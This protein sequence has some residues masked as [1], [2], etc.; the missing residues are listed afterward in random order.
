MLTRQIPNLLTLLNLITGCLSILHT[1]NGDLE[2][3]GYY[4]MMGIILDFSDG[5]VARLLKASSA[6]GKQLDSFSDLVTFGIAPSFILFSFIKDQ[7]IF[8]SYAAFIITITAAIRLARFNI[9]EDSRSFR[10]IPTPATAL[11]IV[12]FIFIETD[13]LNQLYIQ[14]ILIGLISISSVV[15]LKM[16]ALKFSHNKWKGNETK[17]LLIITSLLLIFTLKWLAIPIIMIL[18]VLL[19]IIQYTLIERK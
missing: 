6:I 14:I 16:I 17:Y 19:S 10:G 8:V 9:Q 5:F 3:G 13:F 12:S 18:Y 15:N 1:T 7:H 11:L 2:W 4:I